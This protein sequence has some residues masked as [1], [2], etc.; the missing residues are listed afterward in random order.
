MHMALTVRHCSLRIMIS[1][2]RAS[3]GTGD[4]IVL[5]DYYYKR[6]VMA[7]ILAHGVK[8]KEC[9]NLF[10]IA[11]NGCSEIAPTEIYLNA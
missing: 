2:I 9:N 6:D 3:G 11:N 5:S 8:F 1:V 7:C 4:E 10:S